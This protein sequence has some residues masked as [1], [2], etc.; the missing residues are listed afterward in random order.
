MKTIIEN[1]KQ[2]LFDREQSIEAR[3]GF[4]FVGMGILAAFIGVF[5]C[6]A[7]G[8]S[9]YATLSVTL[10]F[11]L[12]IYLFF[13]RGGKRR[14]AKNYDGISWVVIIALPMIFVF[15]G[16]SLSGVN[17]W[18][19][20]QLFF[21]VL[22]ARGRKQWGM[23]A[24]AT[25]L[26]LGCYAV[27]YI[28]P[29]WIH[30][31]LQKSS[32]FISIVGSEVVV[33]FALC[34]T[35]ILFKRI[36]NE[37]NKALNQTKEELKKANEYQKQFLSSMSH[38]MRSPLNAILGFNEMILRSDDMEEMKRYAQQIQDSGEALLDQTNDILDF[39]KIESGNMT[40]VEVEYPVESL[41]RSC[42]NMQKMKM[43]EKHLSYRV[44]V[45]ENTPKHLVGDEVRI[46]QII[47]NLLTNAYKYTERGEVVLKVDAETTKNGVNL[48]VCVKDSG[49]GI[50]RENQEK[51]FQVFKRFDAEKNRNVEG[52]GLG[53][54]ITKSL[55]ELMN[56]TIQVVSE[57]GIGSEFQ[58]IL[59]QKCTQ[60]KE[61][62]G[63]F[64]M[65]TQ[66]KNAQYKE[67]FQ[68][69]D[70]RILIVDDTPLNLKVATHLLKE[71]R[72]QIDTAISGAEC[73][74]KVKDNSYD[75]ILMD[76]M[77]PQMDGIMCFYELRK[78]GKKIPVIMMTADATSATRQECEEVGFADFLAKP[79]KP[80][81]LEETLK[82]Y[83]P[84]NKIV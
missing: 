44:E 65:E 83:L 23:L 71:T 32:R 64:T 15:A 19:V 77:M 4:A 34:I 10:L 50:S 8:T 38:E 33:T 16:G 2:R 1:M 35:I 49:I 46:K 69:P 20:Y 60:N 66:V 12:V 76:K 5:I 39:N 40:L 9:V 84:E 22:C 36:Y 18:L 27:E 26:D 42:Y 30:H 52:T 11:L 67:L 54:C 7:A 73:L 80:K 81:D 75:L 45:G 14:Q 70:A 6:L 13:F 68:A 41:I 21:L 51:L 62:I 53:L 29:E 24:V 72:I 25:I 79:V 82:K 55:V 58:I 78:L 47:T 63:T 74:L 57:E 43:R 3:I 61:T 59:P 17:V 37:E 56:G 31:F 28:R 48:K